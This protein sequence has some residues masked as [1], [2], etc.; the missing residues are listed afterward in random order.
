MLSFSYLLIQTQENIFQLLLFKRSIYENVKN[1]EK[2][3]RKKK[4]IE[5][6][7]T[8]LQFIMLLVKGVWYKI[9]LQERQFS[10]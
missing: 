8:T 7:G 6:E 1:E 5:E 10:F 2:R 3:K 4:R 9:N